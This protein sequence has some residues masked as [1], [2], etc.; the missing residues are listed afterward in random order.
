MLVIVVMVW[1]VASGLNGWL[2]W[3]TMSTAAKASAL[4]SSVSS[5][6][7]KMFPCSYQRAR[8]T[9]RKI[10]TILQNSRVKHNYK[11]LKNTCLPSTCL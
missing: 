10:S 11:V 5:K 1:Y 9:K 6:P 8:E 7:A 4:C 2:F 3:A